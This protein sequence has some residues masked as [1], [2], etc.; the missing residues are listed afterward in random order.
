MN[1]IDKKRILKA[2]GKGGSLTLELGCGNSK[3]VVG[4]CPP[5]P[6]S[7]ALHEI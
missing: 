6:M 7:D 1:A 5:P 2:I 3:R 4:D